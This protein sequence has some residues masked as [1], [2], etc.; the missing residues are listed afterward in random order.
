MDGAGRGHDLREGSERDVAVHRQR[1][2]EAEGAYA[3]DGM[4]REGLDLVGSE[5]ALALPPNTALTFR[6]S[7]RASPLATTRRTRSRTRRDSVLAMRPGSTPCA[8]AAWATVA[9]LVSISRMRMSGAFSARKRRTDTR[10]IVGGL[11]VSRER[12]SDA[13][14]ASCGQ[15]SSCMCRGSA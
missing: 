1:L 12:L 5:H 15:S 13:S 6:L 14:T 7:S 2:R 9:V 4:A 3:A 8:A 10:L 11:R